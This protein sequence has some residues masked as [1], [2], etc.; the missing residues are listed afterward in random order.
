MNIKQIKAKVDKIGVETEHQFSRRKFFL[1]DR[2]QLLFRNEEFM[3]KHKP[4]LARYQGQEGEIIDFIKSEGFHNYYK[5]RF[6]DGKELVIGS[7]YLE[8]V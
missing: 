1:G 8:K 5:V 4:N 6:D 3:N 2:V 7:V